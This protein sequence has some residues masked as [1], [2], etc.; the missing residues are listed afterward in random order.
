[1]RAMIL[2]AGFGTRLRPLT[3]K[4]PKPLVPV[5]GKPNIVRTIEHLRGFG[6]T[7]IVINL[8]HLP[9]AI[10][11]ALG[12]GAA[13]GVSIAYSA[14]P[15]ILGTGGGIKQALPLLGDETFLVVNGDALFAPDI[16]AALRAHRR[17][18]ALATLV[19]RED[20]EAD[21]FGAVGLDDSDRVRRLVWAGDPESGPRSLMFTG[22][23][24]LEPAIAS[25]LPDDGCIVRQT[26]APLVEDGAP[27]F[28][29]TDDGYFCDLG[30]PQRYLEANLTL[31]TGRE[32]LPRLE[33]P[34][35]GIY[36][37]SDV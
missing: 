15:R 18:G 12:D 25:R 27:V 17:H 33:P 13:W 23:H 30:T 1:M 11:E 35:D 21:N 6:V 20:P 10:R 29:T 5:V 24:L 4:V 36:L 7:E 16:D 26:Y 2:A 31:V 37:G 19:L 8:H 3:E 32:H 22:V 34:Q 9:Q 28:G 14:E